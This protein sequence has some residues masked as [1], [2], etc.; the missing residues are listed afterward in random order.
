MQVVQ[1]QGNIVLE[2]NQVHMPHPNLTPN[3]LV[4]GIPFHAGF[5]PNSTGL[6]NSPI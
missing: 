1:Q 6:A 5:H 4:Q 3:T 2:A